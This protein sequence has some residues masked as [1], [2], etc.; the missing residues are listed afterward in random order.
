MRENKIRTIWGRGGAVLNGW[1]AIPSGFSAESMAHQGWDSLTID[2]QHGLVDYQAAV[3]ML[4][5]ISTTETVP[6][7][8]VPWLEPGIIMK[9]LD[10]GSYG[11]ICPMVN[12]RAEAEDLVGACR[13]APRGRRSFGPSRAV[14]Y[15]GA[16]YPEHANDTVLTIAMIET[17]QA[18]DDLDA[19][20]STPGLDGIYI[21]PADLSLSLGCPPTLDPTETRV[22]EAIQTVLEAAKRHHIAP[23]IHTGSIARARAMI[24]LGFQLVT[25]QSDARLMAAAAKQAVTEIRE[26]R[27]RDGRA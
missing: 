4:Q 27:R 21:G 8:R 20:M 17:A 18:L 12:S 6:M 3:T 14:L 7:A 1:L 15:A 5:A 9:L 2:L 25:L 23:G 11:I 13:Y 26:G 16:D 19:I 24:D 22:V 10:A